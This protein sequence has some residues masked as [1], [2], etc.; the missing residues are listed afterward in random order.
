MVLLNIL[1]VLKNQA[2]TKRKLLIYAES[3]TCAQQYLN[4]LLILLFKFI[5]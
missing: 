3:G 4:N 1:Y 2:H 5:L